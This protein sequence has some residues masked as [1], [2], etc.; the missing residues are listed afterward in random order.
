[1]YYRNV[2][3]SDPSCLLWHRN[4][5]SSDPS[6]LL[7][8]RYVTSSDP[9]CLLWHRYVTSSDPSCLLWHRNVTSSDPSCLLWHRNVTSSDPSFTARLYNGGFQNERRPLLSD[10]EQGR[11]SRDDNDRY[12]SPEGSDEEV[13][14]SN[15]QSILEDGW[16]WLS[17]NDYEEGIVHSINHKKYGKKIFKIRG[18]INMNAENIYRELVENLSEQPTWNPTVTECRTLQTV[19]ENTDIVYNIAAEAVG[20]MVSAR[21]FVNVRRWGIRDG[22]YMSS[23]CACTHPDMPPQKK[24]VR[25][26][27]GA[28]GFI[29]FPLPEDPNKSG[30]IPQTI[31]DQAM[32]GVVK[33][34]YENLSKHVETLHQ[35]R[36]IS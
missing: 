14:R 8:H 16:K 6:C 32:S 10:S 34:F 24:Y 17:G 2:T 29:M 9:S 12:Y 13:E 5:T 11:I 26:E 28:G 7:W 15:Y 25:G 21:D 35:K 18:I 20:G 33:A 27:N 30:W 23:G 31:I 19:D 3:S 36:G 22:I 1:M 4:V